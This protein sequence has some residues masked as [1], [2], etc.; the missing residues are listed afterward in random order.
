MLL[1][2]VD[3]TTAIVSVFTGLTRKSIR[4]LQMI[5][6]AAARV[7]T[8]TRKVDHITPVLR[9]FHW[10]PVDQR[11]DLKILL[12][13]FKSLNGLGPKYIDDLLHHYEA[14]SLRSSGSGLLSVPR[15]TTKH[16]KAAFSY[17]APTI[18][19]KLPKSCTSA[20]T[21]PIFKSRLKTHLFAAAL[22]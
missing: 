13:V 4:K 17:Y 11:I 12:L 16:G 15:I 18:W 2:S 21:L 1:F 9:S 5:Q 10:L 6:N 3:S 20:E 14:S 22:N 19:N 8:D 7:L